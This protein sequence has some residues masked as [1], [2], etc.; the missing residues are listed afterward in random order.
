MRLWFSK[1]NP[2]PELVIGLAGP[3]GTDLDLVATTIREALSPYRYHTADIK[4][5][6][7]I[8][9]WCKGDVKAKLAVAHADERIKLLMN[10]G[11]AIRAAQNNGQAL[12]PLMIAKVRAER[13]DVLAEEIKDEGIE[14]YNRCYIIN[15]LK[16]PDEIKALRSIYGPKIHPRVGIRQ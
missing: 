5:S 10:A 2:K 11:D 4:V 7:I 6:T 9:G 1:D 13:N 3:V 16:H 15:S 8:E 12:V 14:A